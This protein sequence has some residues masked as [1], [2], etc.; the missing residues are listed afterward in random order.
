[1]SNRVR[2]QVQ[3]RTTNWKAYNEAL[4]SHCDLTMWLDRDMQWTH[5]QRSGKRG[6]SLLFTDAAIQ[7]CLTIKNLFGLALR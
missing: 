7:F 5:G 1:M 6:R 2:P 4:K 3:Y